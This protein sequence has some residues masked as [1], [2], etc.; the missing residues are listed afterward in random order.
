MFGQ[1]WGLS[2]LESALSIPD[3]VAKQV[4]EILGALGLAASPPASTQRLT[5]ASKAASRRRTRLIRQQQQ[6]KGEAAG[7]RSLGATE[8]VRLAKAKKFGFNK[9]GVLL[10]ASTG[11]LAF[12]VQLQPPS[13]ST[14]NA[15]QC[16][17][18]LDGSLQGNSSPTFAE[19]AIRLVGMD[20]LRGAI[21]WTVEPV[22]TID[23]S[24]DLQQERISWAR[25]VPLRSHSTEHTSVTLL[26]SSTSGSIYGWNIDASTGL[27]V[28]SSAKYE[29]TITIAN[30]ILPFTYKCVAVDYL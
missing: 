21:V 1:E 2:V 10:T 13:L 29:R 17:A 20:L 25:I 14:F 11:R 27:P 30:R 4:L 9:I 15:I 6:S 18:L 5:S 24:S 23:H 19:A 3:V 12:F 22:L 16:R 8:A 7:G 28:G 26:V